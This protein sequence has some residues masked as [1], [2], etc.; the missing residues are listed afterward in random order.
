M[1][2][3]RINFF[4]GGSQRSGTTALQLLLCQDSR[5]NPMLKEAS[6]IRY[7]L[8]SYAKALIDFEDDTKFYFENRSVLRL[9]Q[10]N[11]LQQFLDMVTT[12]YQTEHLVL[13]EP[14]LTRYF[15]QLFELLP[16]SKFIVILRDP[17]DVIAS[18]IRVGESLKEEGKRHFFQNRDIERLCEHYRAFYQPSFAHLKENPEFR[19]NFI[20]LRYEDLVVNPHECF[21]SLREFTGLDL[22][23]EFDKAPQPGALD[24]NNDFQGRYKAWKT[25][26]LGSI[27]DSSSVGKYKQTLKSE[28]IAQ[29][30]TFCADIFDAFGYIA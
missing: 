17:R 12:R 13:K 22:P 8:E 19:K 11:I 2:S 30:S 21:K 23:E 27:L 18:M 1:T 5:T 9:F 26:K 24:W 25:D 6:Y 16:D 15:P 29:I 20:S 14:H 10:A 28:E 3:N 4:V 7:Q